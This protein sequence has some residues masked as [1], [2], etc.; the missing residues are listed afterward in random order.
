MKRNVVN[1]KIRANRLGLVVRRDRVSRNWQVA[2]R[3][4]RKLYEGTDLAG[5]ERFMSRYAKEQNQG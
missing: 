2:I 4:S 1:V 5:V 3:G